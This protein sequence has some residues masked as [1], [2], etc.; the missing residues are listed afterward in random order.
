M[1]TKDYSWDD[2]SPIMEESIGGDALPSRFALTAPQ[3]V[4]REATNE[5]LLVD[6]HAA[7]TWETWMFPYASLILTTEDIKEKCESYKTEPP[8]ILSITAKST[9]G[10][11]AA[12][13]GQ[14]RSILS[15]EYRA[16]IDAGVN[17]V[18]PQLQSGWS[19]PSVYV[20]YSLK[21]SKTSECYTAYLFDYCLNL[22]KDISV[23]LPHLWIDPRKLQTHLEKEQT[24][25]GRQVSS[26]VVEALPAL[27]DVVNRGYKTGMG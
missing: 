4:I 25:E 17:N 2:Q 19:S 22:L 21:F 23:D 16:A 24:L 14:L 18:L 10:E 11:L 7:G 1:K 27:V 9:F 8:A 15:E 12:A 13:L 26:N 5:M 6:P 3:V 20:N